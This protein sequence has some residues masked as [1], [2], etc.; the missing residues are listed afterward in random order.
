MNK[1]TAVV[2]EILSGIIYFLINWMNFWSIKQEI[3]EYSINSQ[4]ISPPSNFIYKLGS[5]NQ[6]Q[7]FTFCLI[8]SY[9]EET[10]RIFESL[11]I[12]KNCKTW[13][14]Y[15]GWEQWATHDALFINL[16]TLIRKFA[17]WQTISLF[18]QIYIISVGDCTIQKQTNLNYF[19]SFEKLIL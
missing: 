4:I 16:E 6:I 17:L 10:F 1:T 18:C 2:L 15:S 19:A 3:L 13:R 14:K 8:S 12:I 5:V 9:L 7:K 11:I